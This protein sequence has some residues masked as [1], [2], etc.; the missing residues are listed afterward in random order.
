LPDPGRLAALSDF[1]V[2]VTRTGSVAVT[3]IIGFHSM[4]SS[5]PRTFVSISGRILSSAST[6]TDSESPKLTVTSAEPSSLIESKP[7]TGRVSLATT[8]EPLTVLGL[9]TVREQARG[10]KATMDRITSGIFFISLW[11]S[12]F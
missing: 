5:P 10:S 1:I 7:L 8:P 11:F 2:T 12:L 6:T 3:D 4:T 9:F